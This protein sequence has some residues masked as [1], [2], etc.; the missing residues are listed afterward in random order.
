MLN[1][2]NKSIVFLR[3]TLLVTFLLTYFPSVTKRQFNYYQEIEHFGSSA[4]DDFLSP[5]YLE[6]KSAYLDPRN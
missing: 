5:N 1:C 3:V 6:C 2:L 4:G